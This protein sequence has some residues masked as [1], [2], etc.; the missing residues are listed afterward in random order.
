V[1]LKYR[2]SLLE[3]CPDI[4]HRS[5]VSGNAN[6]IGFKHEEGELLPIEPF[7]D[8][9]VRKALSCA[10]DRETM[11]RDIY[12]EGDLLTYP[13]YPTCENMFTP[14]EE[15]PEFTREFFEYD[16]AYAKQLLAD[17]GYP[18]GFKTELIYHSTSS[19]AHDILAMLVSYWDKIGVECDLKLVEAGTQASLCLSH[20]YDQMLASMGG[21]SL[22]PLSDME[23]W[24]RP[25]AN[26]NI[27]NYDDPYLMEAMD[28]ALRCTE[29][30]DWEAIFHDMNLYMLEKAPCISLPR[31]YLE[32]FWWP[33]L[34][35]YY[36][37]VDATYFGTGLVGARI[38]YDED[39]KKELGF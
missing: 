3:T 27:A 8:I 9:R 22:N 37:E 20:D 6:F 35:G 26:L 33:W 2:D 23:S 7:T 25:G 15:L 28:A 16:S 24:V 11:L 5:Y 32:M 31:P 13:V 21:S 29:I 38:W 19:A 30:A 12:I 36:G 10:L 34:K 39:L 18:D 14:I 1:E 17:A 4:L